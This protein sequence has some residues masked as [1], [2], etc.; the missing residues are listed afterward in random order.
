MKIP[1]VDLVLDKALC[2]LVVVSG[3]AE[4]EGQSTKKDTPTEVHAEC[5]LWPQTL[6]TGFQGLELQQRPQLQMDLKGAWNGKGRGKKT[7][8]NKTPGRCQ[9]WW[10]GQGDGKSEDT[11][12]DP[13]RRG[14]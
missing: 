9:V 6:E 12:Q 4:T 7:N 3:I 2:R 10:H 8:Q 14:E 5:W 13:N 1:F 11:K